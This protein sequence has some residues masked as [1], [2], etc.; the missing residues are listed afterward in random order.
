[1]TPGLAGSPPS[2]STASSGCSTAPR[3]RRSRRSAPSPPGG[4]RGRCGSCRGAHS[5]RDPTQADRLLDRPD[6]PRQLHPPARR[7]GP[8]RAGRPG[9]RHLPP[10]DERPDDL[11]AA[12]HR[13]HPHRVPDRRR[14]GRPPPGPGRGRPRPARRVDLDDDPGLGRLA[15]PLAGTLPRRLPPPRPGAPGGTAAAGR[16]RPGAGAAVWLEPPGDMGRP[17]WRDVLEH[18][19]LGPDERGDY[20]ALPGPDLRRTHR[21]WGRIAAKE[22]ARRIEV[23]QGLAPSYPAD[24]IVDPRRAG[25]PRPADRQDQH[26]TP[27]RISIAHID[28]VAVALAVADPTAALG[29]DVEPI[30][31]RSPGFEAMAFSAL[32]QGLLA[33]R[34]EQESNRDEWTAR[35]WCAKEAVAKATG[36]GFIA[37]PGRGRG[38]DARSGPHRRGRD[39][40]AGGQASRG[41]GRSLPRAG[42]RAR[43]GSCRSAAGDCIWAWTT[44]KEWDS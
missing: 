33:S 23:A 16:D 2:R 12:T 39:A 5:W 38:R 27:P 9:R 28:G 8:G 32:E 24:L 6:H 34:S 21:L 14:A 44:G 25:T 10:P 4:S 22:A 18:V 35:F 7:L 43:S 26:R 15:V 17:V 13:R 36:L 30:V 20:L 19:Q 1:M 42:G 40:P 41:T 11:R 29:I 37:G 3:S 31:A